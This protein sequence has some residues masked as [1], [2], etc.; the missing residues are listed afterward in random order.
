MNTF[1]DALAEYVTV[2]RAFGTQF[3]E[4][5]VTLG[6]FVAFLESEKAQF[7]TTPL[8]LRWA[9]QPVWTQRATWAR[10]L[11]MVRRFAA[12]LSAFDPRTEIPP[13]RLLEGRRRRPIT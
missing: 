3:R 4:P 13:R 12:W 5:A 2:R 6:H 11:S 10:R 8:A 7:I 1:Q 9:C